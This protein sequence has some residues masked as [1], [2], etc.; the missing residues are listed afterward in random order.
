MK[1]FT[2]FFFS[3]VAVGLWAQEVE[4]NGGEWDY[5][6]SYRMVSIN[7]S[8]LLVQ[9]IPFN[10][11]NPLLTGPYNAEF[12]SFHGEK[13]LHVSLG[14]FLNAEAA[15]ND[16][17]ELHFNFRIGMEKRRW[18][19]DRWSFLSGWD[20]YF[21]AGGLNVVGDAGRQDIVVAGYG[22]RWS[23]EYALHPQVRLSIETAM[24]LGLEL[25]FGEPNFVFIPPV[26][27]NLNFI[28]PRS[29]F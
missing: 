20:L 19:R 11:S 13:A 6:Y 8:P 25:E 2:I 16:D 14:F 4:N 29:K 26:A 24:L 3:C 18:T 23:M 17:E 21:S 28:I 1:Y 12:H 7:T 15:D 9:M 5:P 10:R 27:L 22:R